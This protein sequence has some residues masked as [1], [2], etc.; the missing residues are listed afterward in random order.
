MTNYDLGAAIFW[1]QEDP[2]DPYEREAYRPC[3]VC[4]TTSDVGGA[5]SHEC[6]QAWKG[7]F[8]DEDEFYG[9]A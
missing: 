9:W 6:Y 4:G 3:P 1:E 8:D 5:C 2:Y 7:G